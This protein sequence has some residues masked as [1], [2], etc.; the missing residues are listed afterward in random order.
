MNR[1]LGHA[2]CRLAFMGAI[3]FVMRAITFG[4]GEDLSDRGHSIARYYD[5]HWFQSYEDE[6]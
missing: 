6:E 5:T 4:A 3:T 2:I 1:L